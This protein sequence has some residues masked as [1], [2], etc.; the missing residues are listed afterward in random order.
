M[1]QPHHSRRNGVMVGLILVSSLTIW[2]APILDQV[3]ED[4]L[5]NELRS[6]ANI[7]RIG[8]ELKTIPMLLRQSGLNDGQ[9]EALV[10]KQLTDA[11]YVIAA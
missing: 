5:P 8:V 3:P 2:A 11:G 1:K 9:I 4:E 7:V 10:K 6:V